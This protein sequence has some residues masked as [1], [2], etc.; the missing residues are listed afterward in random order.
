MVIKVNRYLLSGT[1]VLVLLMSFAFSGY[2]AW[3]DAILTGDANPVY[4]PIMMYHEIKPY[5][6]GKDVISPYEF[7][8]DLK[9]LQANHY[10]TIT[11]T[12]LINYVNGGELL[13]ENPIILSFDDGYLSTYKYAFPLLKKYNAKIVFSIIGKN[14]DD[15]TRIPDDNLD[16]SHVTWEQLNEMIDS[17]LVEVQNHT[18]NLHSIKGRFGCLQLSSESFEHYEQVLTDDIEK[19]QNELLIITGSLPNTFTYPYGKKSDSTEKVIKKL[20]FE[21]TLSCDYGINIITSDPDVLYGLKRICRSHGGDLGKFL[22]EGQKTLR[23][24]KK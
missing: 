15:F 2:Q 13:P 9:Y 12:Q 17:G 8:S 3:S 7:E 24:K 10:N 5:K 21:A 22:K 20:G 4:V 23:L 16:Y 6:L 18:Y 1:L 14:T 19:L 11:M